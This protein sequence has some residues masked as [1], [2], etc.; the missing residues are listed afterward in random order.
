VY[1]FTGE[2]NN[3]LIFTFAV[4]NKAILEGNI[5][6]GS[7]K[8]HTPQKER[9]VPITRGKILSN[10]SLASSSGVGFKTQDDKSLEFEL[11]ENT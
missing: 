3:P 9:S 2:V 10:P 5:S 8:F 11:D 1:I 7:F 4:P 6:L